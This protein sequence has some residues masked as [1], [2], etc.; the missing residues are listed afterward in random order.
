[1]GLHYVFPSLRVFVLVIYLLLSCWVWVWYV[2][3][4]GG[5][6]ETLLVFLGLLTFA[7]VGFGVKAACCGLN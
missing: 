7:C 3:G 1:M 4:F 2:M 5:G 6:F